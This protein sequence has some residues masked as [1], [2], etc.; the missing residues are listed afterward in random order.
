MRPHH[1]AFYR[2]LCGELFGDDYTTYVSDFPGVGDIQT[3]EHFYGHLRS[4]DAGRL[5]AY[6]PED[7][8]D[9][10]ALRCRFLRRFPGDEQRR[11]LAA[12]VTAMDDALERT[13][14]DFV[15]SLTVDC[16][17]LDALRF[18][19]QRRGIP[20]LGMVGTMVNG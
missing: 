3:H 6:L 5:P 15:V 18:A 4:P 7:V 20:F 17:V 19:S 2:R 13:N 8:A 11:L 10:V 1:E 9:D 12:M 16:Y 14:P